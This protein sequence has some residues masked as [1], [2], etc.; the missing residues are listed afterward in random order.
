MYDPPGKEGTGEWL[1]LYNPA[2]EDA[3][4]LNWSVSDNS[5]KWNF[6]AVAKRKSQ[7]VVARSAE[8]FRNLTGC[9][10]DAAGLNRGLNNDGDFL[11]MRDDSGKEIDFVAWSGGYNN[12]YP[13]WGISAKEGYVIRRVSPEN[14]TDTASD[15]AV[16]KPERCD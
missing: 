2:D 5:G 14:D 1:K 7:L 4:M 6:S 12:S 16:A 13:G 8:G 10:A 15:W 3:V 9:D 11:V